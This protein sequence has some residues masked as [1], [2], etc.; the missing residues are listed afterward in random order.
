M[1]LTVGEDEQQALPHRLGPPAAAAK[2]DGGLELLE[3][4]GGPRAWWRNVHA[5][6]LSTPGTA[7]KAIQGCMLESRTHGEHG[8]APP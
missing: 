1:Q 8:G 5:L 3:G 2:E 6:R 4:L 7:V